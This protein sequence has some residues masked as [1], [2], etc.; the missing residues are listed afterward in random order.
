[1]SELPLMLRRD[2]ITW[3]AGIIAAGRP[4]AVAAN[5]DM[6]H[7]TT[8][9]VDDF[10]AHVGHSFQLQ[11][12][13]ARAVQA[14]LVEAKVEKYRVPCDYRQPFSIVFQVPKHVQLDQGVYRVKQPQLGSMSLLLVPIEPASDCNHMEAVFG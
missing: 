13:D 8:P 9:G 6:H 7:S 2:F 10:A 12:E 5:D 3:S 4:L 11:G 1:M 14:K